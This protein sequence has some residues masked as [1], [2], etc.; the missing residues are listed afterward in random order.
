MVKLGILSKHIILLDDSELHPRLPIHGL[1][2]IR[3]DTIIDIIPILGQSHLSQVLSLYSSWNIQDYSD[4]YISPAIIDLNIRRE[5]EDYSSLTRMAVSGGISF[6]L[7]EPSIY[8]I[9]PDTHQN[10]CCDIGKIAVLSSESL[11]DQKSLNSAFAVKGYLYPLSWQTHS[12]PDNLEEVVNTVQK[13]GLPLIIDSVYTQPRL[14]YMASPCRHMSLEERVKSEMS[15]DVDM[16]GGAFPDIIKTFDSYG[17]EDFLEVESLEKEERCEEEYDYEVTGSSSLEEL[18]NVGQRV[19][20]EKLGEPVRSTTI[21]GDLSDGY[22]IYEDLEKRINS[23]DSNIECLSMAEQF[24]YNKAGSTSYSTNTI[25]SSYIKPVSKLNFNTCPKPS[26]IPP[27]SSTVSNFKSRTQAKRPTKLSISRAKSEKLSD[28]DRLYT[29]YIANIPDLWE[30]S[31]IKHVLHYLKTSSIKVHFSNL[32]SAKAIQTVWKYR[33]S[34]SCSISVETCPH[35]LYFSDR[36]I[37][38]GDACF[39]DFPPI[40]S[41]A[42]QSL[43]WEQLKM[44]EID[45]ISSRH[46]TIPSSYKN[47]DQ[48]SF[49]KALNGINCLGFSLQA[50]WTQ[51][52]KDSHNLGALE[53][54]LVRLAK[55]M[56][57]SPAKLL[58]IESRRGSISK[59][60]Y[61]DLIIW[62]PY[63]KQTCKVFSNS[64]ETC[65]YSKSSLYGKIHK[66]YIRGQL[67]FQDGKCYSIG[68][69]RYRR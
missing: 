47:I 59:G 6:L 16:G 53:H 19:E 52:M 46:A 50:V 33:R 49:K 35:Y 3:G 40:R 1:I 15:D 61:A 63:D 34:H 28:K 69:V 54:Y 48:G 68:E 39:K 57:Y 64:P 27:E 32:S 21:C 62:S 66:V 20:K 25:S 36:D 18:Y 11:Q 58:G 37:K 41:L 2:L 14:L 51:L 67:G 4:Y 5:W 38:E 56:S 30:V 43:L 23:L 65:V 17:D 31:G 12:L 60:K 55:W 8:S 7:E 10:L 26:Q 42:N 9:Q 13:A 24:S 45:I 29:N 22:D 44:N